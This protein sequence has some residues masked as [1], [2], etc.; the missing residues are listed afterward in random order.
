MGGAAAAQ[1]DLALVARPAAAANAR[2]ALAPAVEQ[3]ARLGSRAGSWPRAHTLGLIAYGEESHRLGHAGLQPVMHRVAARLQRTAQV[4]SE[5]S[6]PCQPAMHVHSPPTQPLVA[7]A[8]P[9]QWW[10]HGRLGALQRAPLQPG[11]Q[12]SK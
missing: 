11:P 7:A 6:A 8:W 1:V 9:E 4:G 12:V 5:Q 10:G 2:A 3:A